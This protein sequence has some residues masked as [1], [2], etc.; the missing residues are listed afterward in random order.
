MDSEYI[1]QHVGQCLAEGLAEVA[2]QRPVDP[3]QYLA[4]WLYKYSSNVEYKEKRMERLALLEQQQAQAIGEKVPEEVLKKEEQNTSKD[5]TEPQNMTEKPTEPETPA[6]TTAASAEDG[7][8]GNNE[9][10]SS[11]DPESPGQNADVQIKESEQEDQENTE[12]E[13]SSR[14]VG[15]DTNATPK[16][17]TEGDQEAEK[18]DEEKDKPEDSIQEETTSPLQSEQLPLEKTFPNEE[19]EETTAD[20][21]QETQE[22]SSLPLQ[23]PD[24]DDNAD[25]EDSG[26]PEEAT[27]PEAASAQQSKELA[28]EETSPDQEKEVSDPSPE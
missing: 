11:P 2:E 18:V 25:K 27:Q 4:H 8:P 23:N 16:E 20:T 14:N 9:K 19:Q 1:K 21:N 10:P 12:A 3:I 6:G 22:A 15:D 5:P 13:L 28:A 24:K 26:K 7:E 17:G